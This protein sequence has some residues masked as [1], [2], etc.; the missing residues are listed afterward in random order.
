MLVA[1]K[2]LAAK[3]HSLYAKESESEILERSEL[4]SNILPPTPQPWMPYLMASIS[5]VMVVR[6]NF[7]NRDFLTNHRF[8]MALRSGEFPVQS[9]TFNFAF[10]KI[11]FTFSDERHGTISYRNFLPPPGNAFLIS[12]MTFLSITSMSLYKFIIPSIGINEST[13]EK[14]KLHP[15]IFLTSF[16]SSLQ[17]AGLNCSR[18]LI[19]INLLCFLGR[20]SDF[21]L[22]TSLF[23][24]FYNPISR[25]FFTYS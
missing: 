12:G 5:L 18:F 1:T 23:P 11:V 3:L 2:F 6:S 19:L 16:S 22:K 24:V 20:K 10:L 17:W 9:I 8:S 15:N 7:C 14:L 13:T 25:L 4:K 21:H